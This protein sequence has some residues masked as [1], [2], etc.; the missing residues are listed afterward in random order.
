M[1][2]VQRKAHTFLAQFH[3]R[4]FTVSDLENALQAQGFT[5]VEYSRLPNCR[6]VS[7]LL[8]SLQLFDYASRQSAFTY[9]D[10][11]FRIVFLQENL[12]EQEKMVLSSHELGHILCH[13]LDHTAV[14]GP[15]AGVLEEQEANEFATYL[16]RYNQS[17]RP[18]RVVMLPCAVLA[19]L[20]LV[21][22]G[23]V[24]AANRDNP[25]VYLTES[26]ECYHRSDC[27]YIAGK[28]NITAVTLRQAKESGYDACS[29][30]F[31]YGE[32]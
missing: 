22:G 14:T 30:C 28:D 5:L 15:G 1:T 24:Y 9:Q 27:K 23:V 2:A 8:S 21:A 4:P 11:N 10:P 20:M 12:S 3:H 18:R 13:H 32:D 7:T 19:V 17:R 31:G 25:T 29:W 16:M 6:E 26:G